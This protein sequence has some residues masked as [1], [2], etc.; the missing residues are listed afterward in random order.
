MQVNWKPDKKK[1][2]GYFGELNKKWGMGKEIFLKTF[3]TLVRKKKNFPAK[4]NVELLTK[5]WEKK[6]NNNN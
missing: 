3:Y 1:T 4:N 6:R 5:T 2:T